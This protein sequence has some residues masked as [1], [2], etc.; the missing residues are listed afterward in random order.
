MPEML[1]LRSIAII[2]ASASLITLNDSKIT[3]RM[4][5]ILFQRF[6]KT[7][8]LFINAPSDQYMK[9]AEILSAYAINIDKLEVLKPALEVIASNHARSHVKPLRYPMI[10]QALIQAIR[11]VLSDMASPEFIDAWREAF[12]YLTDVL[13]EME[14]KIR[15][16]SQ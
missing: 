13:I 4:Y 8:E 6:P 5:E 9:L 3:S 1:S 11:D 15:E 16:E 7:E 2:K 10:G 14:D 12:Q